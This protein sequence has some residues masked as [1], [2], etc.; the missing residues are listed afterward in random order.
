MDYL[1]YQEYLATEHWQHVRAAA[2]WAVRGRCVLCGSEQGLQVH[3][4]NYDSLGHETPDD[5]TV[6]CSRCHEAYSVG[7]QMEKS[8]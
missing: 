1:S 8:E 7:R 5:V 2:L 3:H 4:V 6:L